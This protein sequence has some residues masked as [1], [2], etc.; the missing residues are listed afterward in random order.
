MQPRLRTTAI[1]NIKNISKHAILCPKNE[2]V[3]K[4]N[5]DILDI[6]KGDFH[7]YLSDNSIDFTDDAEKENFPTKF[8]NSITSLGMPC[9]V[10]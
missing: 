1:D 7:S 10:N 2:Q 5:E 9:V 8:L 3:Q 4:L 6:L